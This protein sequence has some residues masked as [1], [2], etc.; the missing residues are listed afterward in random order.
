MDSY[1]V[2]RHRQVVGCQKKKNNNNNNK[3]EAH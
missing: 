1:G 2:L 3:K